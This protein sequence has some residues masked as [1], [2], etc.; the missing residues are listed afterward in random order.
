MPYKR[1]KVVGVGKGGVAPPIH[2]ALLI[3]QSKNKQKEPTTNQKGA[4]TPQREEATTEEATQWKKVERKRK[5]RA[6]IPRPDALIISCKGNSYAEILKTVKNEPQLKHVGENVTK[7]RKTANGDLL[8]QLTKPTDPSTINIKESVKRA[9]GE[10]VTVRSLTAET[11]VE[12]KELDEV[13][14]K[15]ELC[16]A[17]EKELDGAKLPE[18]SIKSL[19][20]AYS[21]TKIAKLLTAGKIR[22]RWVIC[23]VRSKVQ[24]MQYFKCLEFGHL[25]RNCKTPHDMKGTCFNCGELDHKA[26]EC[27]K[28]C[29]RRNQPE[30]KHRT[31]SKECPHF[32]EALQ[33]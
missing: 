32:V 14:T 20:S 13:T 8:L 30:T 33:K 18:E 12:I 25:A 15:Q 9:L 27:K 1:R 10:K 19:R 16:N 2:T 6:K 22:V 11:A 5:P 17:L 21:G 31:G 4:E 26:R 23:R 24:P 7:V 3:P 29:A 28:E